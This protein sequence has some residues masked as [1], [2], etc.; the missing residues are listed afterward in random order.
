MLAPILVAAVIAVAPFGPARWTSPST[1]AEA[2]TVRPAPDGPED[3]LYQ[4]ARQALS[5]N[6][7]RRA[8]E[9]FA[10]LTKR[11][12]R[13]S[14]AADAMY[15]EAFA[16]YR[17]GGDANLRNALALLESQRARFPKAAT[18]GDADA[19]VT[20]IQGTLARLGDGQA[21]ESV[22]AAAN[23]AATTPSASASGDCDDDDDIKIAALNGLLQMDADRALPILSK[24]LA[25]RD[26]GSVCLRRKAVFLVAQKRSATTEDMLLGAARN[27]PDTEVRSHA[28][29][30]LSQVHTTRAVTALDSI[31]RHGQD[32][33]I[34]EKAVFALSQQ[35]DPRA[36][37][38]L[39]E[40]AESTG[41]NRDIREKA[42][43][44][45]GQRREEGTEYL[46]GLYDRLDDDELKERVLFGV[47]QNG[48]PQSRKWLFEVAQSE[49]N[50]IELRKKAI[51][52]AGQA[53]ATVGDLS[54]FYNRVGNAELREQTIFALAQVRDSTAADQLIEIAR[55]DKDPEMR[56]KALFW[57]SQ[58]HDPRVAGLLE[59]ILTE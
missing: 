25:R 19:L 33:E 28:V 3:S 17:L 45:L 20:R 51:F 12:P 8:A 32:P 55:R 15:W 26:P 48:G 31:V 14:Y 39:K 9:L 5:R 1:E 29:F 16:H 56:K 38:A 30:W 54:G 37:Q 4:A 49:K 53:G 40:I 50:D 18:R 57:L 11:Y 34:Q 2:L 52:W 27:D 10:S 36:T 35:H 43:F 44:W 42:I 46:K 58:R 7:Y 41:M 47:G 23:A 24:V 6:D 21:A 59:Q 22:S 13:S